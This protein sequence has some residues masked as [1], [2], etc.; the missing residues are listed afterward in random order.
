MTKQTLPRNVKDIK[1]KVAISELRR[2][3][4]IIVVL[5]LALTLVITVD[6]SQAVTFNGYLAGVADAL[7][8]VVAIVSFGTLIRLK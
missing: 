2:A 8:V 6:A 3:H 7:L 4:W 1:G 5:A